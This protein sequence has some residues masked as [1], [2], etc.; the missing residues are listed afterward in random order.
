MLSKG[1]G[2]VINEQLFILFHVKRHMYETALYID[3]TH[4]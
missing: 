3:H 2:T 1:H 4:F